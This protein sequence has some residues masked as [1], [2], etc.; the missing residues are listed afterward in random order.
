MWNYRVWWWRWN[1]QEWGEGGIVHFSVVP[2]PSNSEKMN[3]CRRVTQQRICHNVLLMR[4]CLFWD[5]RAEAIAA[6]PAP[7]CG[8]SMNWHKQDKRIISFFKNYLVSL[9]NI[10]WL[11]LQGKVLRR[12]K[13]L[14]CK[15]QYLSLQLTKNSS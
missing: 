9:N 7:R 1:R 12:S 6:P 4:S 14:K 2:Y 11:F 5:Q 10:Q 13:T 8:R 15:I 3:I